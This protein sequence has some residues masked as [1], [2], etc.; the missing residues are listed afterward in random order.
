MA[1]SHGVPD[2]PD[3]PIVGQVALKALALSEAAT[4]KVIFCLALSL[5]IFRSSGTGGKKKRGLGPGWRKPQ[6][7]LVTGSSGGIGLELVRQLASRG[8]KVFAT[9][10]RRESSA[11]GVDALSEVAK[12]GDVTIVEGIDVTS[13]GVQTALASKLS[14]VQLDLVIH[15]A[16]GIAKDT[17]NAG[18]GVMADQSLANVSTERMLGAFQLNTLGPLRVQQALASQMA[19][20]GGKVCVIGTGMGSIG[21]N[22]SGGLHAYR[23]SKAAAHMLAK[24]MACDLKSK[25]IAVVAV[26]P[27]LVLTDFGPGSAVLTK[28]GAMPVKRSCA[29]L[30]KVCDNLTMDTTGRFMTVPADGSTPT[31]FPGGW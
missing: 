4:S 1:L 22:G 28:M 8:D 7:V 19:S 29:G 31:E 16:G 11:T 2:G 10:R 9:C 20:P 23:C 13:D 17:S 30:I 6:T 3:V 14:G 15:N 12:S 5:A 18:P 27:G 26:N 24:G 25:D 21:D